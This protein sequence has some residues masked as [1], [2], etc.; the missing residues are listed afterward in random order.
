VCG[1]AGDPTGQEA[2]SAAPRAAAGVTVM[3]L[4]IHTSFLPHDDPDA[5]LAF[6]RDSLGFEVRNDVGNG[7]LRWITVGPPGQPGTSILL[8][9][10]SPP[11]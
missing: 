8:E 9:P 4:T 11:G 7:K 6:W 10:P 2:S 1:Q 5:A 3:D